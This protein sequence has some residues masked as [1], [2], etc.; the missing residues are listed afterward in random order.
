[1]MSKEE[2]LQTMRVRYV[3]QSGLGRLPDW[4]NDT[5]IAPNGMETVLNENGILYRSLAV[6][7]AERAG[8]TLSSDDIRIY[9]ATIYLLRRF[10]TQAG[11]YNRQPHGDKLPIRIEAH[12]NFIGIL[13]ADAFFGRTLE[14]NGMIQHWWH[15]WLCF[16][17]INPGKFNWEAFRQP[18]EVAIYYMAAK[19]RA[20]FL[21]TLW[22]LIGVLLN[23]FNKKVTM[24]AS[25]LTFMRL[26]LID[27][28]GVKGFVQLFLYKK[29]RNF[30]LR[31][32]A[33]KFGGDGI[34]PIMLN[35]GD[36]HPVAEFQKLIDYAKI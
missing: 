14:A 35:Y 9:N 31:R 22:F 3:A 32:L 17:N 13:L 29:V 16:N 8:A 36:G 21:F 24:E 26:Y 23:A 7:Q 6:L 25:R 33:K 12:D 30:W 11:L 1:M 18:G 15:N 5:S 27:K 4:K 10:A 34:S 2:I 28:V 20:P 19:R